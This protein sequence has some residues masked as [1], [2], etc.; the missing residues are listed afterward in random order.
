MV[1]LIRTNANEICGYQCHS[2]DDQPATEKIRPRKH[3]AIAQDFLA[4][5]SSC[6]AA[7][8]EGELIHLCMCFGIIDYC[9]GTTCRRSLTSLTIWNLRKGQIHCDSLSPFMTFDLSI[10]LSIYL[11]IWQ[12]ICIWLW[13]WTLFLLLEHRSW[14][15]F[16]CMLRRDKKIDSSNLKRIVSISVCRNC[17]GCQGRGLHQSFSREFLCVDILYWQ[18]CCPTREWF[19]YLEGTSAGR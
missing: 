11:A 19:R 15:C 5:E 8:F 9:A 6:A 18:N 14:M 4:N 2:T 17:D 1:S 10:Y 13:F 12:P 16:W 3:G 7:V